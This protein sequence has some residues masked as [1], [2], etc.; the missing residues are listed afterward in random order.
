MN[1]F[2]DHPELPPA[3]LAALNTMRDGGMLTTVV[4]MTLPSSQE[5]LL[6]PCFVVR[7]P[8]TTPQVAMVQVA[9]TTHF[10]CYEAEGPLTVFHLFLYDR[11]TSR[12][13]MVHDRLIG[14]QVQSGS[15]FVLECFLNPTDEEDRQLLQALEAS[16]VI[17][18]EWYGTDAS[19]TYQATR[20]YPLSIEQQQMAR[21][22][23]ERT[24]GM[25]S[26]NEQFL[27]AQL[28]FLREHPSW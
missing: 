24:H 3:L 16:P 5:L 18:I 15:P 1:D 17:H 27:R 10:V 21:Q 22:I 28:R 26:T 23:L 12:V 4:E 14:V 2:D 25:H 7:S 6:V 19:M 11:L 20:R 13:V 9:L 8:V